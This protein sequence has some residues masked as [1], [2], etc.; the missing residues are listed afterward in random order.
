MAETGL[1]RGERRPDLAFQHGGPIAN[2]DLRWDIR[3]FLLLEQRIGQSGEIVCFV[4]IAFARCTRLSLCQPGIPEPEINLR[5]ARAKDRI[6]R[7][8]PNGVLQ[9]D[10]SSLE[11]SLG[12]ILFRLLD[13]D[14]RLLRP[15]G[16]R[17]GCESRYGESE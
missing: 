2:L 16:S 10:L 14:G 7:R 3:K 17:D 4:P 13:G 9:L 1:C 6:L 5:E 15:G 12:D 8:L 11:V